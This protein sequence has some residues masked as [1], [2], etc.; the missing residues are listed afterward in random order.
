MTKV[1][2]IHM[3]QDPGIP[4]DCEV[5]VSINEKYYDISSGWSIVSGYIGY[6]SQR[7]RIVELE[8]YDD[9]NEISY[10]KREW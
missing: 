5:M 2:L 9:P 4:D 1:K 7:Q 10:I 6:R 8:I 3:L